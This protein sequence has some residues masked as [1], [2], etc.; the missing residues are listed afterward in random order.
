MP[1]L[2]PELFDDL[3]GFL[4]MDEFGIVEVSETA[5]LERRI[6]EGT[7]GLVGPSRVE[8]DERFT[9]LTVLLQRMTMLR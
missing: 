6:G 2:I 8:S 3:S 7:G 9:H 5:P 1:A 4:E